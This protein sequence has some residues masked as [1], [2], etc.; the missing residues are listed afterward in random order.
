M[1]SAALPS[2]IALFLFI[3]MNRFSL[4]PAFLLAW[5]FGFLSTFGQPNKPAPNVVAIDPSGSYGTWEGWG[6]SLAWFAN[7]YGARDD[8]ADALF[9]TKDVTFDSAT[10][11][12]LGMTI[13]RYNAGACSWKEVDGRRMVVSKKIPPNRQM[14]GFWLDG[15]NPDPASAS[16]D[17]NVDA[18][19]RAM[20]LKARDRGA[21]RF[22][23]FSNSPM[24]W[25]CANDNPSG[26]GDGN[27]DN[28]SEKYDEAFAIYL[29]TIAKYAKDHWGFA[30]TSVDPFNEPSSPW[31]TAANNQEGCHF[32]S[33]AQ[34][35]FIPVLR[36][37]LDRQ[38]L[39]DLPIAVSDENTVDLGIATWK[40]FPPPLQG[41]VQKI[42]VHGYEGE[43]GD[44]GG[45]YRLS[46][47]GEKKLW[48]SEYGDGETDGLGLARDIALDLHDLHP[49]A[50]CNW[51]PV[52]GNVRKGGW[53]FFNVTKTKGI[54]K[55]TNPKYFVFAQ[56]SRHIRPGMTI[57]ES[58]DP[59]TTAAYDPVAHKLVIV[60]F[61]DGPA[62][63]ITFDLSHFNVISG[64]IWH[65]VTEP[66]G[67]ARYAIDHDLAVSGNRLW[68]GLPAF[69]IQTFELSNVSIP[70]K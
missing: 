67:A 25:M 51:Q 12:G 6:T 52:D 31:W 41:L 57:L 69:S 22:E 18:N 66:K 14:E 11:P 9:A 37:E 45:L 1:V 55:K 10:L 63:S 44:R 3:P 70:Q 21:N 48:N 50:W 2:I 26:N 47:A 17:W 29:A 32:G 30:F 39:H 43:K 60:T 7:V 35:R 40:S 20:M 4:L 59:D 61:N 28:L 34:A 13:V 16:W 68:V 46:V 5:P 8:I 33:S 56:Y 65:A 62:R 42:N 38:G 27:A 24:W 19:Q 15:I 54:L 58:S 49:T 64:P 36:A 23:L 53:G